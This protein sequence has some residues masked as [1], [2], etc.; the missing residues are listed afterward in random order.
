MADPKEATQTFTVKHYSILSDI[1]YFIKFFQTCEPILLLCCSVEIIL[2]TILP[3]LGIYLP[4][5]AVDLVVQKS[6][7]AETVLVLSAFTLLMAALSGLFSFV[8]GGK[9]HLYNDQRTNLL[10]LLFLKSLRIKYSQVECGEVR[11]LYWKAID[12]VQPGDFSASSRMVTGTVQMMTSILCVFLYTGVISVLSPWMMA[13]ILILAVVSYCFNLCHVRYEEGLR[14]ERGKGNR[15]FYC[16]TNAMG[17]VQGAKDI[18]I[19]G[20]NHWLLELRDKVLGEL[21]E[22]EKKSSQKRSF[23]EKLNFAISMF[24]DLLAYG[25]LIF[26]AVKGTI[27]VSEFVLYFGAITGFSGFVMGMIDGVLDLRE[28]ANSTDYIRG[29]LELPEEDRTSGTHH[30]KECHLPMEIEFKNVCFSYKSGEECD[31][32]ASQKGEKII[33]K[34]FNLNIHAGENIALVGVNGAGKTTLVK[35]LCGMYEPDSGQILLNGIDYREFPKQELYELFSVVFQE[36]MIFPFTVGENLTLST[37]EKVDEERAWLALEK[38]GLKRVFLEKKINMKTYMTK[39]MKKDG[40][41][42]SG[43][44]QQRFLLARALY[45]DAPV[46]VLDE[47]TAALDPIAESEVYENYSKYSREKTA[48]FISHR[49]ASTRFSDRIVMIEN[50]AIL[51]MGTHEE[52]MKKKGAYFEMF[53]VQSSYYDD[54]KS[55]NTE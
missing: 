28:A 25:F 38:A 35:L 34:N 54:E 33:F 42:L 43:G 16:V 40:I 4:K 7:V 52:L 2:G 36:Q 44:Q 6:P 19:F 5:I 10:G 50:G 37:A 9:Y 51:E 3:L 23:Y 53:Q 27:T 41:S 22:V 18:R 48:I 46:L 32:A 11:D 20:M 1:W 14:D 47:P 29:Y 15:R 39:M 13:A 26:Q 24:R 12:S 55:K 45:K 31:P 49:L 8:S 30:I 17:N 21:L